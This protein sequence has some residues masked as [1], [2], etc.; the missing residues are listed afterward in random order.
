[1]PA[2]AQDPLREAVDTVDILYGGRRFVAT[3]TMANRFARQARDLIDRGEVEL[4][5]LL[6]AEG[7]D[8]LLIADTIPFSVGTGFVH[9]PA[10][11]G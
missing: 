1:V 9:L 2:T 3:A 11:H 8:L 6:H 7:V 5:A 4:V 10:A